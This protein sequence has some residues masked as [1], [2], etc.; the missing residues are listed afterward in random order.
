MATVQG[1]ASG[2]HVL[3]ADERSAY[4]WRTAV[5]LGDPGVETTQWVGQGP[6]LA[7]ASSAPSERMRLR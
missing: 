3:V 1:D 4:S 5:T 7:R 6:G 2:L